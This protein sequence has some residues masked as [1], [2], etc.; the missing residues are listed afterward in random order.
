MIL[1]FIFSNLNVIVLSV[2]IVFLILVAVRYFKPRW[3]RNISYLKL[4]F[5]TLGISIFY[6]LFVSWGQYYV[7][8]SGSEMTKMLVKL[9]LP[10]QA[11]LP[12]LLEWVRPFFE[13]SF[14]Y[15][16]YYILGRVWLNIFISFLVSGVLYLIF[17]V[18]NRY[19]GSF[20]EEGPL[21]LLI[22]MLIS[23]FPGVLVS[24]S[25]GF[26]LAILLFGFHYLKSYIKK[27]PISNVV[28]EPVFFL[29][30]LLSL[31]FTNIILS[32]VL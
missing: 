1:N 6:G 22:L 19:R 15:F 9:P 31:L 13:N 10:P 23:G 4:F 8:Q 3:V 26:I 25:L 16:L 5:I 29:S 12:N 21:L 27:V 24:I 30:V 28:I 7:W 32:Y 20:L 2:W 18:W 11:P 17:K 14:G